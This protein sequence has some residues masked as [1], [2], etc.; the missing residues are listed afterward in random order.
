MALKIPLVV[1]QN[2]DLNNFQTQ[3]GSVLQPILNNPIVL[4][5]ALK[6]VALNNGSTTIPTTINRTLQGWFLTRVRGQATVWDS[7]DSNPS[8]S[9]T[10][11][12]NSNAAVVVDIWVF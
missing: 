6:N 7:Q 11:L 10:L 1:T 12:L 9:Q 8:P 5:T 2:K 4:G 3:L